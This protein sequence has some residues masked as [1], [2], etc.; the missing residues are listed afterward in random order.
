MITSFTHDRDD[1]GLKEREIFNQ[2]SVRNLSQIFKTISY[3]RLEKVHVCRGEDLNWIEN[4]M[5]IVVN[6]IAGNMGIGQSPYRKLLSCVWLWH[7]YAIHI[8]L[9]AATSD[10]FYFSSYINFTRTIRTKSLATGWCWKKVGAW[11]ECRLCICIIIWLT[12]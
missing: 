4:I 2:L 9:Y 8:R 1:W 10:I 12:V 7:F 11:G 3:F 6:F 5:C